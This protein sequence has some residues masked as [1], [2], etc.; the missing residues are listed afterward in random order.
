MQFS[1]S[2]NINFIEKHFTIDNSLPG[3]DNQFSLNPTQ[4]RSLCKFRD[5][6]TKMTKNLGLKYLPEEL[7]VR[8]NYRGRWSL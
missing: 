2:Y 4:M 7:D 8:E 5:N 6:Y 3:R 1:L